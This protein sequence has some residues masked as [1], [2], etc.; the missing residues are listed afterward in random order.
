MRALV[1][2][3]RKEM[4]GYFHSPIAYVL[5]VG[6][7]AL[8]GYFFFSAVAIYSIA[9]LQAMQNPLLVKMNLQEMVVMPLQINMSVILMLIAP[10]IT[11]RLLAE[12]KRSGTMELMVSYPLSDTCLV[13]AKF[14]AAWSFCLLML[15]GTWVHIA[16]LK[17]IAGDRLY[18]PA[19]AVGYLGL[20]LMTGAFVAMGLMASALT[21]NQIVAAVVG[22]AGLLLVWV[23][24]WSRAVVGAKMGK[25]LE[26]LSLS[27]HFNNFPKGVIDSFDVVYYL[28]FMGLLL[29]LTVRILEAKRW[30]G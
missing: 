17:W 9:S 18:L 25:L 4:M 21:E 28:L 8:S 15:A 12:E 22:F 1:A 19:V 27:S 11:M 14:L 10:L 29:F 16:I 2:I 3:Y 13:L 26:Q 23:I 20:A 24:G 7:L 6:F 5:L 30:K